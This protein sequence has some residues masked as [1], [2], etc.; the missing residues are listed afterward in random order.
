MYGQQSDFQ[1]SV[2]NLEKAI[3]LEPNNAQLYYLGGTIL[4]P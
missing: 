1:N 4:V 2:L 3:S